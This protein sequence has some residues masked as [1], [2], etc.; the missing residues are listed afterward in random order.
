MKTNK[1]A[2]AIPIATMAP[3]AAKSDMALRPPIRRAV[4]SEAV[5]DGTK[6]AR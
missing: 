1:K 5:R 6:P 4:N 2:F 3:N